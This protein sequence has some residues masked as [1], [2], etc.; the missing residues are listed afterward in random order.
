MQTF[1]I[2]SGIVSLVTS[3]RRLNKIKS[4]SKGMFVDA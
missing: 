3:I 2:V 4:D 1:E